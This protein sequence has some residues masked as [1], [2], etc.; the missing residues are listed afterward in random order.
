M[1][2][3]YYQ[4]SPNSLISFWHFHRNLYKMWRIKFSLT[5]I[6]LLIVLA[7]LFAFMIIW[8]I[9][10]KYEET[11]GSLQSLL[12]LPLAAGFIVL[13][14]LVDFI[15][16]LFVRR[17]SS[18]YKLRGFK[19]LDS[20]IEFEFA[21]SNKYVQFDSIKKMEYLPY[22]ALVASAPGLP[23]WLKAGANFIM[24]FQ[25]QFE[26]ETGISQTINIP[27]DICKIKEALEIISG[28]LDT[29][30]VKMNFPGG[31]PTTSYI[32]GV[33][34]PD[35]ASKPIGKWVLLGFLIFIFIIWFIYKFIL[36]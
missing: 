11:G 12:V 31:K 16:Y 3:N 6:I 19:I 25:I 23:Y 2:N 36:K 8:G 13:M 24:Y 4:R 27:L 22:R 5:L 35:L 33:S 34:S 17:I 7:L 9:A 20:G 15:M 18:L 32:P 29:Q 14:F 1:I 10:L 28:K 30:K 26:D 21:D